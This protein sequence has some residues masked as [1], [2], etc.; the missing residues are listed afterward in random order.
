MIMAIPITHII[1]DLTTGGSQKALFRLLRGIDRDR[2]APSVVTLRDGNAPIANDIRDLDIPVLDLGVTGP[3]NLIRLRRLFSFFEIT[4][5]VIVHSWLYHAVMT[6]RLFGRTAS[7]PILVSARRNINL[8]NPRR[9]FINRLTLGVDDRIIAVS[10]AARRVE[11]DRGGASPDR[12][13]TIVNGVEI[14]DNLVDT[15]RAIAPLRNELGATDSN[16]VIGTIGRLHHEKGLDVFLN[17]AAR[18]AARWSDARFVIIGSGPD[19]AALESHAERV[20][21]GSNVAFLGE[22]GDAQELL[23]AMDLFVLSSPEEGMPNVVLEA[24]AA[25][26][27]VVA[28]SVG[29]TPEVVVDGVTGLLVPPGNPER[30]AAAIEA[31]LADSARMKAMGRQGR[32]RVQKH[33]RV[34]TMVARTVAVYEELLMEKSGLPREARR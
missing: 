30:L 4:R 32:E 7:V 16:P 1:T 19:R 20:G 9:E 28:T 22:R 25:A 26:R 23:G 5:P 3:A 14:S 33:F 34:D 31:V 6:A 27:P 13:V 11:I 10:E 12:V 2:F 8:G 21:I 18:I 15:K 17:A 29:G 24:M